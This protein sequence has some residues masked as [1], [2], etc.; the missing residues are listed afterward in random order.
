MPGHGQLARIVAC[1]AAILACAMVSGQAL[2]R[3]LSA[4]EARIIRATP[5]LAEVDKTPESRKRYQAGQ[6]LAR[7]LGM[8][9]NF[10]ALPLFIELRQIA[11]LD[12]FAGA[13]RGPAT[14]ELE[15]LML[16]H[17]DDPEIGSRLIPMLRHL[18]S[19]ALFAALLAALP[20]GKITCPYLL[21]TAITAEVPDAERRFAK[22]LPV[23][24]P[25]VG[26][27]I[28]QR[29]ADR[30]YLDGASLVIDLLRRTPLDEDA[31][32]S[33]IA[34]QLTR[35]PTAAAINATA[36][37][38]IEI[39]KL[40]EDK[41]APERSGQIR[42]RREDIPED[43]LLCSTEWLRTPKPLGK[44]RSREIA[45]LLRI[46]S[47]APADATLDR[48]L[49]ESG[50]PGPFSPEERKAVEAMLAERARVEPM[51]RDLTPENLTRWIVHVGGERMVKQFIARGIDVNALNADG[52]R[53]LVFA[54]R[55]LQPWAVDALLD[56]G[57]DPNLAN[58]DREGNT[59]LHGVSRHGGVVSATV[60]AG[61][62]IMKQLLARKANPRARNNNGATPLQF[63]ANRRPELALLLLDVG[64]DVNAADVNG[65]TPLHNAAHSGQKALARLLLDR[66]ANVNA[67]ENGGMTPLLIAQDIHDQELESLFASRGG[68]VN[69]EFLMKREKFKWMLLGP[70]WRE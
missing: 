48:S 60:D 1:I 39:A 18:R 17:M 45:K 7:K 61:V 54:A 8:E 56:A 28:A 22:L 3:P 26:R 64:A 16:R 15:A 25:A 9:G 10:D 19:P 35:L 24:H 44:S 37:K 12:S 50:A 21:R 55:T 33:D 13:Y 68:R 59:A 67:E 62:L 49:F 42:I 47:I 43:G 5:P 41:T 38:L 36:Q 57:A 31:T 30:Q 63:A 46:L 69:K 20:A 32:I 65:T 34:M 66:G 23:I 58:Q 70:G 52:E 14:P 53:P 6:A 4:E 40:P 29:F 27:L 2:A 11:Q 51:A